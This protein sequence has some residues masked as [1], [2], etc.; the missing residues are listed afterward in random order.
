L[1]TT[2]WEPV[3]NLLTR[4]CNYCPFSVKFTLYRCYIYKWDSHSCFHINCA[5]N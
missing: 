2:P 3:M 1:Y 4:P 5:C